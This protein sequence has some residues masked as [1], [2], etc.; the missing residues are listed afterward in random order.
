MGTGATRDKE[1]GTGATRDKEVRTGVQ[2][3]HKGSRQAMRAST[4]GDHYKKPDKGSW[5]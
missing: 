1:M 3:T 4:T 5:T 2:T